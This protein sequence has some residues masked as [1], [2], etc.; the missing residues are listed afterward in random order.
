MEDRAAVALAI[1]H[2]FGL[3]STEVTLLML[4]LQN[5]S[6]PKT[7]I[8]MTHRTID[9]HIYNMRRRLK[10]FGIAIAT[11]WGYG[12]QLPTDSRQRILDLLLQEGHPA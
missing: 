12:Y 11:L 3:T 1:Q 9:V 7:R 10:A 6:V 2:L 4:L 8:N 5:A